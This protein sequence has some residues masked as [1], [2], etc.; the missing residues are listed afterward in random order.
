MIHHYITKYVENGNLYAESWI[1]IDL[2]SLEWCFSKK[3]I[4]IP[5][6]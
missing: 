6:Q 5:K 2:F 3:K 1:Q 4:K